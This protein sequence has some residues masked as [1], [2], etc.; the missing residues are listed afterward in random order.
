MGEI[1]KLMN[2]RQASTIIATLPCGA[3][4]ANSSS[5]QCIMSAMDEEQTL[6]QPNADEFVRVLA[7]RRTCNDGFYFLVDE[8]WYTEGSLQVDKPSQGPEQR[9]D[10]DEKVFIAIAF[11]PTENMDGIGEAILRFD[12]FPHGATALNGSCLA[13]VAPNINLPGA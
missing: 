2:R 9:T 11:T 13:S 7:Y 5:H 10:K 12:E 1:V 3:F 6:I 4:A 8:Q